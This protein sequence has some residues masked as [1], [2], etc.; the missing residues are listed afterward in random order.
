MEIR[1][2]ETDRGEDDDDGVEGIASFF[3]LSLAFMAHESKVQLQLARL[4]GFY[5]PVQFYIR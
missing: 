5:Y 3:W 2:V 4:M 1:S